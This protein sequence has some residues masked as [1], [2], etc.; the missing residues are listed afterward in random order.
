MFHYDIVMQT[1]I[2]ERHGWIELDLD[3]EKASGRLFI[4]GQE[5]TITGTISLHGKCR[6]SGSFLSLMK[7]H[8][9]EASGIA[10]DAYI[11]LTLVTPDQKFIISG[12]TA[13]VAKGDAKTR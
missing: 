10:N 9:Y 6:L 12:K 11:R 1:P 13:A 5:N 3:E 8:Y 7:K 2:G 4:L